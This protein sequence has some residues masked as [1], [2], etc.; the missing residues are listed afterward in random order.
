[1]RVSRQE[2][3]K[4]R[5][6]IVEGAARLIREHGVE[7]TSV[8]EAMRLAGLTHGG[9]YRHFADKD[10]LIVA[11][12]GA[13]FGERLAELGA[14]FA[15][16]RPEAVVTSYRSQYLQEGHVAAVALGCPIPA[17]ANDVARGGEELKAAYGANVRDVVALLAQGMSGTAREREQGALREVAM[18]AGA[19]LIAR[20]SDPDTAQA[21]LKACRL[22]SPG[23]LP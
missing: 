20:A 11:A 13:A 19:I 14:R 10:A 17:L 1:M 23:G 22:S 4:T 12:L 15:A 21:L 16:E 2:K 5:R 18:L 7:G 6:R 8:A 9:F 3:E